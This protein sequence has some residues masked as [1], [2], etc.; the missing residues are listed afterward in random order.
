MTRQV[1]QD[2]VIPA[3][4]GMAFEVKKGAGAAYL[5]G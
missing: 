1:I 2:T 5:S 4:H 3:E